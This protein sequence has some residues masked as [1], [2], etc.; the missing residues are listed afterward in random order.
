[1]NTTNQTDVEDEEDNKLV[2]DTPAEV[3]KYFEDDVTSPVDG[4]PIVTAYPQYPMSDLEIYDFKHGSKELPGHI[5]EVKDENPELFEA[6][7][8]TLMI[9]RPKKLPKEMQS[10]PATVLDALMP[11]KTLREALDSNPRISDQEQLD[12]SMHGPRKTPERH[13]GDPLANAIDQ[14]MRNP[15]RH[16]LEW[17]ITYAAMNRP[18]NFVLKDAMDKVFG[19]DAVNITRDDANFDVSKDEVKKDKQSHGFT[20]LV[21]KKGKKEKKKPSLYDL[22]EKKQRGEI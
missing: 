17:L 2:F 12:L 3:Q 1:M 6:H 18:R 15:D 21:D 16:N 19:D 4:R 8:D 20:I 9:P 22:I 7:F 10:L 14:A 5:Q 11:P 13:P